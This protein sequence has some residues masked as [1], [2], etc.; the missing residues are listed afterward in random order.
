MAAAGFKQ[1]LSHRGAKWIFI[2]W[3]GFIAENL[4]LSENRESLVASFGEDSY[5]K[6]YGTL[7]TVACG[8][9]AYG[10][11]AHG[12]LKGPVVKSAMGSVAGRALVVGVQ[13]LGL[14]GLSQSL[15][16]FQVPVWIAPSSTSTV[17]NSPA[18]TVATA[19]SAP[20]LKLFCPI[21]FAHARSNNPNELGLKRVT[22]HPQ[23]FSLAFVALGTALATPF[24]TTR[25]LCGFPIVFAFIGGAHQ[26]I[27]FL[28]SGAYSEE[29]YE[30][31]SLVPFWALVTGKQEWSVLAAELKTVNATI[32]VLGALWLAR[33]RGF[34]V[35]AVT[36]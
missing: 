24:L 4:I 31:T 32:G 33:R 1:I 28:R 20:S 29:Y 35:A 36:K 18:S 13:V 30:S 2:G 27:R 12:H 7:S 16:K 3:T 9:I 23:L 8:S 5:R 10:Y 22:R 19:S 21:D 15:P 11:L 34:S 25:L 6:V 17:S 26:D 14:V